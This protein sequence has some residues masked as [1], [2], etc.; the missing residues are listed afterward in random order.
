MSAILVL[1]KLQAMLC[2]GGGTGVSSV[3]RCCDST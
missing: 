1:A 3:M 2:V